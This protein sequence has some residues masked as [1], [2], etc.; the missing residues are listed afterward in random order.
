[1]AKPTGF[2]EYP[3]VTPS[4]RPV[5]ER[6]KDFRE[7]EKELSPEEMKQQAARCMDCGVPHCHSCGC[8]LGNIIPEWNDLVYRDQWRKALDWLH[9]T[10]NFPEITGRICPAPCEASCTLSI[11]QE[12]VCIRQ[13]ELQIVE[14]GWKEGWIQPEPADYQ[15]G[16]QIAIIGSGPSGLSAAQQLVRL[17]HQVTVFEKADR[18]GG[19]LRY[20]IPDFKMEKSILDR[21]LDQMR[22]E[23]VLFETGVDAGR[24]LSMKYLQ[25]TFHAILLAMGSAVP[26]DIGIPGRELK[27]IHFAMDFL[28]QQNRKVAGDGIPSQEILSPAGKS[29]VVL[30]GGDTGSD[31]VGTS[32][33]LGAQSVT[34]IEILPK[35]P[36][37]RS[38]LNPWPYWPNIMRTSSSQEEG[39]QRHWALMTKEFLGASGQVKEIR[40]VEVQP[41]SNGGFQEI[42]DTERRIPADFVLISAGFL[43]VEHGPLVREANIALDPRGSIQVNGQFHTAVPGVFAAG[44]GV[45][46]ASLVVRAIQQGRQAAAAI[47]G[48]LA[49]L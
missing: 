30:G 29:V 28:T 3:R 24:D 13:I 47:Q 20:G 12:P 35:P 27:G 1:M 5:A 23:G 22:A 44:D 42:P 34:Q 11:H 38:P 43:H 40:C 36:V 6:I 18:L 25:R 33:R 17:G 8:P 21:R 48:Y 39:C 14:R 10:N 9:A 7:I 16:K 19:L 46:G 41:G 31:C 49:A 45:T 32:L 26:R 15:S 37:E 2:M 4:K